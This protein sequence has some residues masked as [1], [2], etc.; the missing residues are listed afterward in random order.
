[1]AWRIRDRATFEALRRTGTRARRGP[2]TVTYAP[3]AEPEPRVAYAIG[4][5]VGTAVVR[6][7]VRRRLRAAIGTLEELVPGAYLVAAGP[8]AAG[9]TYEEL[10]EEV[11]EATTAASRDRR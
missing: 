10:R 8:E 9:Q 7:R 4:R 5:R 1:V 3:G 11:A 6:N 2:V